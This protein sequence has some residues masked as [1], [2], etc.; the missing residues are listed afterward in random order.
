MCV[1]EREHVCVYVCV[2]VR[3]HVCV[4]VCVYVCVCVCVCVHVC[5]C[6][7]GMKSRQLSMLVWRWR[8]EID[9]AAEAVL[10]FPPCVS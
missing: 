1:C 10:T 6:V 8:T 3:E 4:C 2:C 5:V 7:D 9:R